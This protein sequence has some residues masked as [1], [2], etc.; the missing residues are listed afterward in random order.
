MVMIGEFLFY[1][2]LGILVLYAAGY[3]FFYIESLLTPEWLF[4]LV[5]L[6]YFI[7]AASF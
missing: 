3:L 5:I 1:I 4:I 6:A 2:L 7:A